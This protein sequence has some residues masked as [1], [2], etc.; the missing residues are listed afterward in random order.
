MAI[1]TATLNGSRVTDARVNIPAWGCWYAEV[2]IDGE[3][4]LPTTAAGVELKIADLTLAGTVLSG[5]PQKGRASYRIVAGRGGWGKTIKS[6][7]YNDDD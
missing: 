2:T 1:S 4:A 3:V 6:W 7:K 5:G